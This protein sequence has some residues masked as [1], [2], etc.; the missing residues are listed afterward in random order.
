MTAV[1]ELQNLPKWRRILLL[2]ASFL[3]LFAGL[4]AVF[5]FIITVA[6]AWLE[7]AQAQWPEAR[8][9]RSIP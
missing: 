7:Q 6:D 9:W 3:G 2:L 5:A 8:A 1:A 4:C